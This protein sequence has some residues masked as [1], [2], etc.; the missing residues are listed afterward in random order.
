MVMRT[1][2][3]NATM[4]YPT[5]LHI[6]SAIVRYVGGKPVCELAGIEASIVDACHSVVWGEWMGGVFGVLHGW[7]KKK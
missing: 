3:G 2:W 1:P 7:S 5:A 6:E 4:A